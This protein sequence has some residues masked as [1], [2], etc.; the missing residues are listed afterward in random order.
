MQLAYD[1]GQCGNLGS[2]WGLRRTMAA[3]SKKGDSHMRSRHI[4]GMILCGALGTL[5]GQAAQ[6]ETHKRAE[7]QLPSEW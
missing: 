7:P 5:G 1:S 4:L 3:L 2:L 6:A